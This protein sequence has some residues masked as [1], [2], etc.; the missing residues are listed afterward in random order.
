MKMKKNDF[1]AKWQKMVGPHGRRNP[2]AGS[3]T[4]TRPIFRI[5]TS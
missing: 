2:D 1:F 3:P 4:A 5:E